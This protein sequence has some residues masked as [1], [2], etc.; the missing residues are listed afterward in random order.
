MMYSLT[1]VRMIGA[2]Q[3]AAIKAEKNL[4]SA[5]TILHKADANKT[6]RNGTV[7]IACHNLKAFLRYLRDWLKNIIS[8]LHQQYTKWFD[9]HDHTSGKILG[10]IHDDEDKQEDD[11]S[12]TETSTV[13]N[14]DAKPVTTPEVHEDSIPVATV[15]FDADVAMQE[16][17][18][19]QHQT[20][21]V[22]IG[23]ADNVNAEP[24]GEEEAAADQALTASE[25]AMA[26]WAVDLQTPLQPE[27]FKVEP[28]DEPRLE[29]LS[30]QAI[31]TDSS[32]ASELDSDTDS[33]A[34]S[35]IIT[36]SE[37]NAATVNKTPEA[38]ATAPACLSKE[39]NDV[40]VEP[41]TSS[42][43]FDA[44]ILP[45]T[46][47]DTSSISLKDFE[48]MLAATPPT[49]PKT[50]EY[51]QEVD[52]AAKDVDPPQ[53][54]DPSS[55]IVDP[56][57]DVDP[58]PDVD[59]S[60]EVLNPLQAVDPPQGVDP[61]KTVTAEIKSSVPTDPQPT[62]P[63]ATTIAEKIP[64]N[65][66]NAPMSR[67]EALTSGT[68][69]PITAL[70]SSDFPTAEKAKNHP[71][72][73]PQKATNSTPPSPKSSP[74]VQ[75]G[76]IFGTG[77]IISSFEPQVPHQ[78][79]TTPPQSKTRV[80][81]P[82]SLWSSK[83]IPRGAPCPCG[84]KHKYKK[85]C[86]KLPKSAESNGSISSHSRSTSNGTTATDITI[87][88]CEEG[89]NDGSKPAAGTEGSYFDVIF[90]NHNRFADHVMVLGA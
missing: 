11:L 53:A 42:P 32:L 48:K 52:Q 34:S 39:A 3:Y 31:E 15:L 67:K 58:S 23:A 12:T 27:P 65:T 74:K 7:S 10:E 55:Q 59:R 80:V 6:N 38:V 2:L 75:P 1:A 60:H 89:S 45:A 82:E 24:H 13:S 25:T 62:K 49:D 56:S 14:S 22:P 64:V 30:A 50:N 77:Q 76:P 88:E 66:P 9:C 81:T 86:G 51:E 19:G 54:V 33:S 73:L 78:T 16:A 41:A 90:G 83:P 44:G 4:K 70:G 35:D 63:A 37:Y 18:V 26:E 57:T 71:E 72:P 79:P 43:V 87:P 29:D 20:D 85:C 8:R 5:S 40:Q 21:D 69:A 28:E 36:Q 46:V 17:I 84:S 61:A 47:L 68:A